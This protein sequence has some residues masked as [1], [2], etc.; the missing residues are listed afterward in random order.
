MVAT[1]STGT[2]TFT[3]PTASAAGSGKII[4]LTARIQNGLN[5]VKGGGSDTFDGYFIGGTAST[6]DSNLG[7]FYGAGN[8]TTVE[9][10]SDGSSK[11]Y[12]IYVSF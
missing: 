6:T 11:W 12:V 4:K 7:V 1:N 2:I 9:L 3:L 8:P 10:I 5:V